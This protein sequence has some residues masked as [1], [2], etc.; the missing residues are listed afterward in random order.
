MDKKTKA[1]AKYKIF[2]SDLRGTHDVEKKVTAILVEKETPEN[3]KILARELS[4][5]WRRDNENVARLKLSFSKF[6]E[7]LEMR[8]AEISRIYALDKEK[9]KELLKPNSSLKAE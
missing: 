1:I 5:E 4:E 3:I 7:K 8:K 2:G 9:R 6:E